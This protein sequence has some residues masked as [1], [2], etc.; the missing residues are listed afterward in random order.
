M[1]LIQPKFTNAA[2]VLMCISV[3]QECF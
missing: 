1:P 2:N 3:K